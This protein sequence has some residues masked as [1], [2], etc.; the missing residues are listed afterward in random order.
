MPMSDIRKTGPLTHLLF[1]L[2]ITLCGSFVYWATVAELDIVSIAPGRV[3]PLGRIKEVQHLEGG[4]IQEIL[5]AEGDAIKEGDTL[6]VLQGVSSDASVGELQ[7]RIASLRIELLWLEALSRLEKSYPVPED[8]H[9]EYPDL[10][11]QV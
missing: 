4:I 10:V 2:C 6:L 1:L 7:V 8:L 9:L 11:N 3:V 5:V